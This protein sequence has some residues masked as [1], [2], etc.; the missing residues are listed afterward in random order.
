MGRHDFDPL[1]FLFGL[2]FV[3]VG[4]VLLGGNPARDV[5]SLAWSGPAVA[6]GLGILIV[7]AVRPRS[8]G[9]A[10]PGRDLDASP[11][12]EPIA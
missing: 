4:L 8:D 1:S 11:G 7:I 2:L 3:G 9:K 6:V 5:V 12:E 10:E